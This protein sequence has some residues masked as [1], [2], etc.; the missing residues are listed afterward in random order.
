M[1]PS[2]SSVTLCCKNV[3]FP[4]I[5]ILKQSLI[6]MIRFHGRCYLM[7]LQK[8]LQDIFHR[9]VKHSYG[10][11][12]KVGRVCGDIFIRIMFHE[13]IYLITHRCV[14]ITD[15]ILAIFFPGQPRKQI[16][17]TIQQHLIQISIVP[18]NIF[19]FPASIL[20]HLQVILI[21]IPF[22]DGTLFSA[23]FKYFIFIISDFNHVHVFLCGPCRY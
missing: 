15:K 19:I 5:E 3:Y 6:I 18:I 22:F 8:L 7:F 1:F 9:A 10:F 2:I 13:T 4:G 14:R 11:A 20:G 23:F 17:F 21:R 16:D 12:G